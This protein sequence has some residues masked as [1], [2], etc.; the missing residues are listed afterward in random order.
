MPLTSNVIIDQARALDLLDQ[1]RV[2]VPEEIRA[3]KR[4]NEETERIVERAQEEAERILAR[5][6]EQAAFLIEE[7]ELTRAA[8]IRSAEII[9]NGQREA[10]EIRRGADEYAQ[11][12]LVKL[13]GE[14]I[15][16]LQSIKRGLAL[17]DDRH[18]DADDG[19]NADGFAPPAEQDHFEPSQS[20]G[21]RA[22]L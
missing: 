5:A 22:Q 11:S 6:Q 1:L 9:A 7:R 14:C 21:S 12:V 8:E 18:P 15:R 2:A 3:A 19:A 4:I 10:D 13:E 16:A 17:L 20:E